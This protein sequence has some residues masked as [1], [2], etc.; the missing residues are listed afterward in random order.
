M[1]KYKLRSNIKNKRAME[2]NNSLLEN[3]QPD[4]S[5]IDALN[6][7]EDALEVAKNESKDNYDKYLRAVAD[8]QN[9]KRNADKQIINA[10][11]NAQISMIKKLLPIID[12]FSRAA[13]AGDLSTGGM[14]IYDKFKNY[15]KDIGVVEINPSLTVDKFN[16]NEQE[17][18][19]VISNG[20]LEDNVIVLVQEVGYKLHDNIIRYAK[21]IVNKI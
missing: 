6:E 4:Y 18:V 5:I 2:E 13:N 17:A 10:G 3:Y 9:Y 14:L 21:V 20:E 12:D 16:D 15:L 8:Y 1:K 19:G 7:C 11:T